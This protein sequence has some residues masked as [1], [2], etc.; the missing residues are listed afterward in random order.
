MPLQVPM[1]HQSERPSYSVFRG[2]EGAW[3]Q[4]ATVHSRN[5]KKDLKKHER[6]TRGR[7]GKM[8]K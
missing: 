5:V 2:V 8:E 7:E 6:L 3:R 1:L 4:M